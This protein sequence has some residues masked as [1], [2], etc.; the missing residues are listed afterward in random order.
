MQT[1][2]VMLVKPSRELP[3]AVTIVAV[4]P[5]PVVAVMPPL[6]LP[7]TL[8]E[9]QSAF[10]PMVETSTIP[11]RILVVPAVLLPLVMPAAVTTVVL[12]TTVVLPTIVSSSVHLSVAFL[13]LSCR[14]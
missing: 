5:A 6:V 10:P 13:I 7:E 1:R 12:R 4:V 3:A 8:Q 2:V 14:S 11:T 9:V